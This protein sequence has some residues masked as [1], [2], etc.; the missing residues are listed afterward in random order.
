MAAPILWA[1]GNLAFLLQEKAPC[2]QSFSSLGG[3]GYLGFWGGG[4][5]ARANLFLS[6]RNLSDYYI[7]EEEIK[8]KMAKTLLLSSEI[9]RLLMNFLCREWSEEFALKVSLHSLLSNFQQVLNP[10][11]LNP[12]PATC[13]KRKAEVVLQF[14]GC[15]AAEVA[16]QHSLLCSTDIIFT[17]SC[18]ATNEKLQCN[19]EKVALRESGTCLPLS[20]G[21]HAPMFRL[22]C[23]DLGVWV[24]QASI[25]NR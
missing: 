18:A 3:R 6:A 15:C 17:K 16:L 24:R 7:N 21:F 12:T 2:P 11:P 5:G 9:W 13:Q 14:S 25:C 20:C 4:L 22:P 8:R 1:P 19:F 10:T 23:F